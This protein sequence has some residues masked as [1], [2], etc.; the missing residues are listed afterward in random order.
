[1]QRCVCAWQL[2]PWGPSSWC[3]L[4]QRDAPINRSS[5]HRRQEQGPE[6]DGCWCL[7]LRSCVTFGHLLNLSVPCFPSFCKVW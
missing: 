5:L 1:M 2:G 7:P 4:V 6:P 3:G